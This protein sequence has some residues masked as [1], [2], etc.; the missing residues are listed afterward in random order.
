MI[1]ALYIGGPWDRKMNAVR[2]LDV[3]RVRELE[4]PMRAVP[5]HHEALVDED[6]IKTHHY[7]PTAIWCLH[8]GGDEMRVWLH[9]D[10]RSEQALSRLMLSYYLP[11]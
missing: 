8:E 2:D 1:R 6:K 7:Y 5:I 11:E 10:L 4:N 9:E 3:I